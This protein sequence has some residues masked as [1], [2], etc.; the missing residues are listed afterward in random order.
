MISAQAWNR[1]YR[2]RQIADLHLKRVREELL[3]FLKNGKIPQALLFA[4]PKGTGK[5]SASRIIGA[6]LNDE[7]NRAAVQAAY[8]ENGSLNL[9]SEPDLKSPTLNSIISGTSYVVIELDAASNRGI[10]DVRL[11]KER[12]Q[13]PPQG[14][15]MAVY[16]LD[17]VHMLTT[18]AFNAL[19]KLLE[20]PPEHAVFIL[21]TTEL[22]KIPPTI[23]SRCH[24]V[25]FYRASDAELIDALSSILKKEDIPFEKEALEAI[26]HLADG[27]FRD[28]VK[29]LESVSAHKPITRAVVASQLSSLPAQAITSLL[30]AVLAKNPQKIATLFATFREQ[31]I[32]AKLLHTELLTALHRSLLASLG[33]TNETAHTTAPIA[34]YLLTQLATHEFSASSPIPLLPLE[35]KLLELVLKSKTTNNTPPSS[36]PG[37]GPSSSQGS[38][39]RLESHKHSRSTRS[40]ASTQADES[41]T[42]GAVASTPIDEPTSEATLSQAMRAE[43]TLRSIK[44][45]HMDSVHTAVPSTTAHGDGKALC[46]K[47]PDFVRAVGERN[48]TV[49]ALLQSAQPI[50]GSVG[51]AKIQV[52]Y[53]FHQEQLSQPKCMQLTDE[54]VVAISGGRINIE[55][56]LSEPPAQAEVLDAQIDE[57]LEK[58]ATDALM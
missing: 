58:L 1:T 5:T 16:I 44:T 14:A 51:N 26:A 7:R 47:W 56:I 13:L 32:S 34:Q 15:S 6:V 4:G 33:V 8:F 52:F 23:V 19:L 43:T 35:L 18:E 9:L 3:R 28:A 25:Q 41:S 17:E 30:E 42:S 48:M 27:S 12:V 20:E 50:E 10:D 37:S 39:D 36:G 45:D 38:N 53:K 40:S 21:A 57:K 31:N 46:E 54:C 22:H 49:A 11:L 29:L 2:P 55:F 24:L